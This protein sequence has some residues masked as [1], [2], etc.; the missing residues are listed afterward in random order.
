MRP[1]SA[2]LGT[3]AGDRAASCPLPAVAILR[4]HVSWHPTQGPLAVLP[5]T[6]LAGGKLA[7]PEGT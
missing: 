4:A 1:S 2:P 5:P 6:L 3:A 7:E